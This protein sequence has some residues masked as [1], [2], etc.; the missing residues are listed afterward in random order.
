MLSNEDKKIIEEIIT[1]CFKKEEGCKLITKSINLT[2][3]KCF[4]VW[5]SKTFF[6]KALVFSDFENKKIKNVV[7]YYDIVRKEE[8]LRCLKKWFTLK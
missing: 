3:L 5:I 2:I 7:Y 4:S 8:V 1:C 6:K